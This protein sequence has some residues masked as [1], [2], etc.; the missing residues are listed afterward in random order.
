MLLLPATNSEEIGSVLRDVQ[1]TAPVFPLAALFLPLSLSFADYIPDDGADHNPPDDVADH[2][3][4]DDAC[5]VVLIEAEDL[6]LVGD[7]W[8]I[9]D[10]AA[11]GGKYIVWEGLNGNTQISKTPV[12]VITVPIHITVAGIYR[13]KW[14]MRQPEGV[15]SDQANDSWLDFPDAAR[16]GPVDRSAAGYGG[17][18]KVYGNAFDGDFEFSGTADVDHVRTEVAVD[19]KETGWYTMEIAGRS[20]GHQIDQIILFQESLNVEDAAH[21]CK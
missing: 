1:P 19:F 6:D 3:T 20:H 18:V 10:P 12:D 15:E 7:W 16:F 4:S 11:S 8:S 2:T 17:F 14:K 21:G 5:N 13:F 9:D